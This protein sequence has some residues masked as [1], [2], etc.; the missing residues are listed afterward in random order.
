MKEEGLKGL[1]CLDIA[2]TAYVEQ[3]RLL[4]DACRQVTQAVVGGQDMIGIFTGALDTFNRLNSI[5]QNVCG[6]VELPAISCPRLKSEECSNFRTGI[7]K[8]EIGL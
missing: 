7:Q 3:G 8:E 2:R 5:S 1:S 4:G 6:V